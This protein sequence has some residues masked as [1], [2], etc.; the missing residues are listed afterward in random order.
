M[1]EMKTAARI[2]CFLIPVLI[3]AGC[4]SKPDSAEIVEIFDRHS[5]QQVNIADLIKQYEKKGFSIL[6][7]FDENA[8]YYPKTWLPSVP[9]RDSEKDNA[10]TG[11]VLWRG[12]KLYAVAV[13]RGSPAYEAGIR[14][15]DVITSIN[16]IEVS[17]M[18]DEQIQ[19]A[20]YGSHGM[21]CRI[22]GVSSRGGMIRASLRREFGG[23][24]IAWGFNIPGTRTGYVRIISF[25]KKSTSLIRSAMNN[26]LDAGA[27]N[28]IIDLRGNRAG[29]LAELSTV[30]SYFAPGG[31]KLFSSESRHKGYSMTFFSRLKG[32]YYGYPYTIL[33]D[34]DTSSRAE[35][36]AQALKE[37]GGTVIVGGRTAGNTAVTRGFTLKNGGV[38]R[39]TVSKLFPPSGRDIDNTGVS[40]DVSISH[41]ASAVLGKGTEYPAALASSDVLLKRAFK[42]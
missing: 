39:I 40:P 19:D 2:I 32:S 18:R 37:W 17:R 20:L 10:G 27:D 3:V 15:G 41:T 8:A 34:G 1:S 30:L 12:A 11:L 4:S 36:F 21:I 38:V 22:G 13:F 42:N 25:T 9:S 35:I 7:E 14:P 31:G 24:P 26:V 16:D 23:M 29:S 28:V 5:Y 33:T 6:P